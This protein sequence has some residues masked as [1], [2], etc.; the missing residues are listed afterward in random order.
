MNKKEKGAI[1]MKIKITGITGNGK[2]F[3]AS[4]L[5]NQFKEPIIVFDFGCIKIQNSLKVKNK[6]ELIQSIK[7]KQNIMYKE[8]IKINVSLILI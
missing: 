6:E 4:K 7:D 8:L 2:S 5:I 3:F 1:F